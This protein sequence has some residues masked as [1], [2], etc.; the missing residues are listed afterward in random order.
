MVMKGSTT[1]ELARSNLRQA[2]ELFGPLGDAGMHL[3]ARPMVQDTLIAAV[4]TA[5]ALIG[6]VAHLPVDLPEG[7]GD[8]VRRNL[9]PLGIALVLLQTVPLVWR[10]KAPVSVLSVTTGALFLFTSLGYFHSFASF[11]F[12]VALFTVA[13]YEDRRT[14]IRAGIAVAIV[15]L[16]ILLIGREPVEL[17]TIIAEY[18]IVGAVW[19]IGDGVRAQRGQVVQ[20]EDRATRLEREQ[21]ELA[22][23]AVSQERRVIA[24]ELHDVVA[25]NV[26]V[27]VAQAGAAQ[28]IVDTQPAEASAALGAIEHTGRAALVEM[29]RLMGFLRT[30]IDR[31][32]TRSPQPGLGDLDVL[33]THVQEAGLPVTLRIEGTPRPLPAGLDLSAFRIVQEALTNVL[34]HAGPARASVVVRY[35]ES[36]LWLTIDDDG[37]GPNGW[38]AGRSQPRYGHLGMRERVALFG[39]ELRLGARPAGGYRVSVS[40]P[41][42]GEPA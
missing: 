22:Q 14:S 31:A 26:S 19:F 11:G 36:R 10:R 8:V 3:L 29:R 28:R 15:V 7:G 21:D 30:E 33:V 16:T 5:T 4:L 18:L 39:G 1:A 32:V 42:D 35:E 13:A 9:D 23:R 12:L 34:K 40:L 37:F 2:R 17:D 6:V 41:L 27:I 25:H 24:R 20:L 38:R